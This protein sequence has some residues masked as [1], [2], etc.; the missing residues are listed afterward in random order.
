MVQLTDAEIDTLLGLADVV[1]LA[2][3]AVE[4]DYS[5]YVVSAHASGRL[6]TRL[7]KQLAQ[8][9]CGGLAL[10]MTQ[11]AAMPA[12]S[13]AP[14]TPCHRCAWSVLVDVASHPRSRTADVV[15]CCTSV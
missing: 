8:I 3:T 5:G 6:P 11:A 14:S 9:A 7:A 1:T 12:R 13:V 4:L 2:R 15:I 10:G